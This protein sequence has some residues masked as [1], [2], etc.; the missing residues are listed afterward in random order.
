MAVGQHEAVAVGPLGSAGIVLHHAAVEHVGERGER[1]RRALVAALG[2]QRASMA[3]PRIMARSPAARGRGSEVG[4]AAPPM[5]ADV[6][7]CAG[8]G[9]GRWNVAAVSGRR[10]QGE[11]HD[12]PR[13]AVD[14]AVG[15]HLAVVGELELAA[16]EA[17][18]ELARAR[19]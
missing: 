11:R 9:R 10:Q 19:R 15:E 7:A 12:E 4:I 2:L 1:H 18:G 5:Q 6:R 17:V 3:K 13:A 14:A 8:L 16:D